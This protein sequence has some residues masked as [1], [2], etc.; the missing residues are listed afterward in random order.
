MEIFC[1]S[2]PS[3]KNNFRAKVP[4]EPEIPARTVGGGFVSPILGK[5]AA[6]IEMGRKPFWDEAAAE[7]GEYERQLS[8]DD[9]VDKDGEFTD[10]S[11]YS[12]RAL[13]AEGTEGPGALHHRRSSW[14][15]ASGSWD[16]SPEVIAMVAEVG[17]AN[18]VS[19]GSTSS[20]S[21]VAAQAAWQ[22][23]LPVPTYSPKPHNP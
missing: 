19:G 12:S 22:S 18:R 6:D 8:N 1:T 11:P 4:K 17:S 3:S 14:G 15:R 5:D 20:E 7:A 13:H 21:V 16:I 10:V 23:L 2:I 9:G